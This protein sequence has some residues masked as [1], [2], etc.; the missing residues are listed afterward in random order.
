MKRKQVYALLLS[1]ALA[2]SSL[3]VTASAEEVAS[4]T[5]EGISSEESVENSSAD[6][7]EQPDVLDYT[8]DK[9]VID[10]GRVDYTWEVEATDK[11]PTLENFLNQYTDKSWASCKDGVEGFVVNDGGFQFGKIDFAK[12]GNYKLDIYAKSNAGVLSYNIGITVKVVDTT[13]PVVSIPEGFSTQ[14]I[15]LEDRV[16]NA[17]EI[18]STFVKQEWFTDVVTAQKDIKIAY[19]GDKL[20]LSKEGSSVLTFT[21]TDKENNS[22]DFQITVN[23][24]DKEGPEIDHAKVSADGGYSQTF[25]ASQKTMTAEDLAA[26]FTKESWLKDNNSDGQPYFVCD[27]YWTDYQEKP[28][29]PAVPGEYRLRFKAKDKAGNEGWSMDMTVTVVDKTA[30][31]VAIPEDKKTQKFTL[32]AED[33]SEDQIIAN[34]VD[35]AWI[36]DNAAGDMSISYE[37]N[38]SDFAPGAEGTYTLYFI[39]EDACGNKSEFSI[40]VKVVDENGPVINYNKIKYHQIFE[41]TQKDMSYADMADAFT[42]ASW[43]TD[44]SGKEVTFVC[45]WYWN[46]NLSGNPFDPGKPGEY[47]LRFSAED[48]AGNKSGS[49]FDIT[50][51]VVDTTAPVVD[52]P[53]E[54]QEQ[55]FDLT[56]EEMSEEDIINE[57]VDKSWI[58]D[59]ADGEI[60]VSLLNK[61]EFT[62]G[63]VGEYTL[64]FTASDANDNTSDEFGIVVKVVD[65]EAPVI[66]YNKIRDD[67]G[68][69][70]TVEVDPTAMTYEEMV[71]RFTKEGW[72]VDNSGNVEFVCDK[73][74][75]ENGITVD[76][77]KYDAFDS[78][79]T[80]TYALQFYAKDPSGNESA[81]VVIFVNVK[82]TT[83]PVISVDSDWE[84]IHERGETYTVPSASVTDNSGEELTASVDRVTYAETKEDLETST[85]YSKAVDEDK[86]GWYKLRY[87]AQDS[88]GNKG[89]AT[90][91]V[92]VQDTVAPTAEVSYSVTEPTNQFVEVTIKASEAVT[93]EG[94]TQDAADPSILRKV[95]DENAD[96][97][98]TITDVGGN[99]SQVEVSVANIDKTGPVLD[100][101][102]K[103]GEITNQD[104]TVTIQA[105]ETIKITADGWEKVND[106][107]YS[108][109][110]KENV[111][112]EKVS[113]NDLAGNTTVASISINYIDKKDPVCISTVYS[114][115]EPTNQDVT[116]TLTFDEAVVVDGWTAVG[117]DGRVWQ[118]VYT[119][120]TKENVN[121]VD[122]A[123]NDITVE[124]NVENIDKTAPKAQVSYSVTEPTNQNVTVTIQADESVM[125]QDAGW[126]KVSEKEYTKEFAENTKTSVIVRDLA[127]NKSTADIEINNIDKTAPTAEAAYSSTEPTNEDVTAVITFSEAVE[128]SNEGWTATDDTKTVWSR[129]FSENAEETV[130]ASDAAGNKVEIDITVANIDKT[131]AEVTAVYST[132]DPTNKDVTVIL[133][134]DE[135]IEVIEGDGNWVRNSDTQLQK[136][137][138]DNTDYVVKV[139]D[140]A[141]NVTKVAV[142][143]ENIDKVAPE[144]EVVYSTTEP[145]NEDV[146]VTLTADEYINVLERGSLWERIEDTQIERA[147]DENTDAVVR[148]SD[149]AGNV[150]DVSVKIEN[151]D[152]TAPVISGV[153]DGKVYTEKVTAQIADENL[154]AVTLNGKAYDYKDKIEF[155][156]NGTYTLKATD[157]AGNET[158]VKFEVKIPKSDSTDETKNDS[159]EKGAVKTGDNTRTILPI[160]GMAAGLAA[161]VAAWRR[162]RLDR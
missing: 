141:G 74:V 44:D 142:K 64:R 146:I 130:K 11:A 46:E 126:T 116:V 88:S 60:T 43:A 40:Q 32:T 66:D 96:E 93:A 29:D 111:E 78:T 22:A 5:T 150:T 121:I 108:K 38:K 84:T 14:E 31:T 143:I 153:E 151:I 147:Y 118:K 139:A 35:P 87:C 156:E 157:A 51:T 137:F 154:A 12:P 6:G 127:G 160:A 76:K 68:Y 123:N 71:G 85:Q 39:A 30:P 114:S 48:A 133:D 1:V 100:V 58:T 18:I 70:Q 149:A 27:T 45:D 89:Y 20:D 77:T 17:D 112:N 62:P 135:Y 61:E 101:T 59:N 23:V 10:Y 83:A 134:A 120:N 65:N 52:V 132:T 36:T 42:D 21:A 82:D 8:Q 79:K 110:Y 161:A 152:K 97:T 63:V 19:T 145:T 105:N 80:G 106:T 16:M 24:A 26:E 131:P 9:P 109:V 2:A 90:I 33:V 69:V 115:T 92:H 129:T 86:I 158:E 95:Y 119:E 67:K 34:F 159:S 122:Q 47:T 103:P 107:T 144:V 49:V 3:P 7:G 91:I 4:D 117:T 99:T 128:V 140:K 113:V 56:N 37:K 28:F 25:E 102:M 75:F 125:I 50:V 72:A 41:A 13:A 54:D 162:R 98:V 94:W 81:K 104:V 57:F 73:Y 155:S 136:T 124:V 138:S 15:A 55:E 148:V 53:E